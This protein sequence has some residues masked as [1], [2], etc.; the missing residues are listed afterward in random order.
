[1]WILPFPQ[2]IH[3]NVGAH[4]T[5]EMLLFFKQIWFSF[6]A[7]FNWGSSSW[8]AN[9][10]SGSWYW[11]TRYFTSANSRWL[12]R[13]STWIWKAIQ[14]TGGLQWFYFFHESFCFYQWWCLLVVA[15]LLKMS[16]AATTSSRVGGFLSVDFLN[17]FTASL[18]ALFSRVVSGLASLYFLIW[19][20]TISSPTLPC[21]SFLQISQRCLS[22]CC[23][24][25]ME[26]LAISIKVKCNLSWWHLE[27]CAA[28][29]PA[30]K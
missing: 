13:W 19:V 26:L 29:I 14:L 30:S 2:D 1:M 4:N 28:V 16:R 5:S 10:T 15:V 27:A 20:N 17:F 12:W 21:S 24:G 8:H 7:L 22:D 6:S 3:N 9:R 25:F 18:E 23:V 11:L